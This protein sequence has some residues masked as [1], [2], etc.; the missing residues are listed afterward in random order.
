MLLFPVIQF[1]DPWNNRNGVGKT[2]HTTFAVARKYSYNE[3]W[4]WAYGIILLVE[5]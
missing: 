5:K 4:D 1:N 3:F 2:S